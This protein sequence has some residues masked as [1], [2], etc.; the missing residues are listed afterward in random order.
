MLALVYCESA[1]NQRSTFDRAAEGNV[2]PF[3]PLNPDTLAAIREA[4]ARKQMYSLHFAAQTAAWLK[5]GG[6]VQQKFG[7]ET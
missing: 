4:E 3:S 5:I 7:I 6:G 2:S 1:C